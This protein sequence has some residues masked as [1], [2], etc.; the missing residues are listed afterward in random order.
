MHIYIQGAMIVCS[1][2][3]QEEWDTVLLTIQKQMFLTC[4]DKT[5]ISRTYLYVT[6]RSPFLGRCVEFGFV[7]CIED[8]KELTA[9]PNEEK[10]K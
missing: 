7:W 2:E 9:A 10:Q 1:Q 5:T 4:P 8:R 3:R 6:P